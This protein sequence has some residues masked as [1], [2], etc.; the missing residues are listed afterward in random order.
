MLSLRIPS[1]SLSL[2][3]C[4]PLPM[5]QEESGQRAKKENPCLHLLPS[6]IQLLFLRL[7]LFFFFLNRDS[8]NPV[9]L[10]DHYIYI[11]LCIK[12]VSRGYPAKYSN[13]V[14]QNVFKHLSLLAIFP[15]SWSWGVMLL[16]KLGGTL[17]YGPNAFLI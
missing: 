1:Q 6:S 7:L 16:G 15:L 5:E 10:S 14:N 4:S 11:Y 12:L 2:A 9:I 8:A 3:L 13:Y 17:P